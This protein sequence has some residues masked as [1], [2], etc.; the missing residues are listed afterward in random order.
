MS[1]TIKEL[2][3]D[4]A[5]AYAEHKAAF[6]DTAGELLAALCVNDEYAP[7][8][9]AYRAASKYVSAWAALEKAYSERRA[10]VLA[11]LEGNK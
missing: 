3:A 9:R 2:E 11:E 8:D 5:L 6:S 7:S 10:A 1:K 4:V